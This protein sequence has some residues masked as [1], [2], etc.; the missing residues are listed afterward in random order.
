MRD[1]APLTIQRLL[2]L[3][4][5]EGFGDVD[6]SELATIAENAFER[7][8][9]PGSLIVTPGERFPGAYLV[10]QGR[11]DAPGHEWGP[12]RIVGGLEMIA[13]R[14]SMHRIVAAA[15]TRTLLLPE[16]SFAEL[17]EDNYGVLSA[18]RRMISRHMLAH[19]AEPFT[20]H[21]LPRVDARAL[22]MVDRMLVLRAHLPFANL[23]ALAALAQASEDVELAAGAAIHR[24]GEESAGPLVV[25]TGQ[26]RVR[27]SITTTS[28]IGGLEAL[29][30]VPHTDDAH[31]LT[32][33]HALR[34]PTAALFD[35]MEDHTDFAIAL[36]RE[37]AG[38]LL[39]LQQFP[40]EVN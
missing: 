17:L 12:R 25:L 21:V 3:R 35:V 30:E 1:P 6:L 34:L 16:A 22:G 8:F 9:A 36:V 38:A 14:P 40:P 10:V 18:T 37:L 32:R 7:A 29:A 24:A 33:V 26:V 15:P 31:A 4:Q 39:D 5:S 2:T 13:G 23:Q 11:L 28:Q 27:N 19:V 20:P